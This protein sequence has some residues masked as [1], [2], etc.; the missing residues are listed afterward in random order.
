MARASCCRWRTSVT[1]CWRKTSA[2]SLLLSIVALFSGSTR[3]RRLGRGR[4]GGRRRAA[5]SVRASA[6]PPAPPDRPAAGPGPEGRRDDPRGNRAGDALP[7]RGVVRI[8]LQRLAEE[9]LRLGRLTPGEG[10]AAEIGELL[11]QRWR[12]GATDQDAGQQQ[13]AQRHRPGTFAQTCGSGHVRDLSTRRETGSRSGSGA[14]CSALAFILTD[15]TAPVQAGQP[16]RRGPVEDPLAVEAPAHPGGAATSSGHDS[17]GRGPVGPG[18]SSFFI[19]P[20]GRA[21]SQT[22]PATESKRIDL[23][24]RSHPH[25]CCRAS[26]T[27][28]RFARR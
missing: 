21:S 8:E 27:S 3:R 1:K 26:A 19:M 2:C 6:R 14:N 13:A 4:S 7:R 23:G 18:S 5:R 17:P 24:P 11:R 20:H 22:H 28:A 10:L 15:L 9:R 12:L 16:D 25:P